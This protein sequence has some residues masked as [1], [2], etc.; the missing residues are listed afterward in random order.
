MIEGKIK[1]EEVVVASSAADNLSKQ[2]MKLSVLDDEDDDDKSDDDNNDTDDVVKPSAVAAADDEDTD[3]DE[4]IQGLSNF[5]LDPE[6]DRQAEEE[7]TSKGPVFRWGLGSNLS[8]LFRPILTLLFWQWI[9]NDLHSWFVT[10][11]PA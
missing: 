3:D 2:V 5:S 8:N 1:E 11:E 10:L 9:V 7:Y 6:A 4:I